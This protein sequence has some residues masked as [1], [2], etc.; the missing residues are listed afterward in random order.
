M[1]PTKC[2]CCVRTTEQSV[3]SAAFRSSRPCPEQVLSPGGRARAP[4]VT[5]IKPGEIGSEEG[6][7]REIAEEMLGSWLSVGARTCRSMP[8]SSA[9]VRV[10]CIRLTSQGTLC[11][12]NASVVWLAVARAHAWAVGGAAQPSRDEPAASR[13]P[14]SNVT[15]QREFFKALRH[16]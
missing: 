1:T 12:F 13:M 16:R 10:R 7:E 3:R 14:F 15:V 5:A 4:A 9:A 6:Q 2:F 8:S 11:W